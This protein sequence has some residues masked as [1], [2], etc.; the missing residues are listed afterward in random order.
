MSEST[1]ERMNP[2]HLGDYLRILRQRRWLVG[3]TFLLVFGGWLFHALSSR[4]GYRSFALLQIEGKRD[5]DG[6]LG[7]LVALENALST[8]AEIEIMRSRRVAHGAAERLRP[9]DFFGEENVYRPLEV[10]LRGVGWGPA[11]CE[12]ACVLG[13]PPVP[14]SQR[15]SNRPERRTPNT[16]LMPWAERHAINQE[17]NAWFVAQALNHD[18][19]ATETGALEPEHACWGFRPASTCLV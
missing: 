8:E 10:L 17:R 16:I 11:P 9:S 4:P 7:E 19:G 6:L 14:K 2:R 5:T 1:E 13:I 18:I 12:A 15:K 3:A